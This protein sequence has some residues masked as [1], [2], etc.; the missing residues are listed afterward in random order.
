MTISRRTFLGGL[1]AGAIASAGSSLLGPNRAVAQRSGPRVFV[2]RED[3][4]GRMFPSLRPFADSSH[5]LLNALREIG[6][7][8]SLLDVCDY[9]TEVPEALYVVPWI[10]VD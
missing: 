9:L 1:G 10:C 8:G 2:I 7:P 6:K 5:R 3:R 4:F